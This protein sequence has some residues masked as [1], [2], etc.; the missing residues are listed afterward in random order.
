MTSEHSVEFLNQPLTEHLVS[1]NEVILKK[2]ERRL[3]V[4]DD[5]W[6]SLGTFL[7]GSL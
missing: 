4:H 5:G 1:N 6:H 2:K 3:N 7:R